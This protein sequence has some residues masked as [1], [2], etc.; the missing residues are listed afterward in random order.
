MSLSPYLCMYLFS[1]GLYV[2][3][4]L[5]VHYLSST[6]DL[7]FHVLKLY[8]KGSCGSVE[9]FPGEIPDLGFNCWPPGIL[10]QWKVPSS[11]MF[12][13]Q[14]LSDWSVEHGCYL[15]F[16]SDAGPKTKLQSD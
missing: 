12:R 6:S 16:A 14:S 8:G 2:S 10:H 1:V 15:L 5:S 4:Y 7:L 9:S 11:K 13:Q 3:I